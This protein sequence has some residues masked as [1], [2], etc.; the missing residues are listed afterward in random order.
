MKKLKTHKS[1]EKGL[2]EA[3]STLEVG[4]F[5]EISFES[6][7][8]AA[9]LL[10]KWIKENPKGPKYVTKTLNLFDD[11]FLVKKLIIQRIK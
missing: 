5:L 6:R 11:N 8:Y 9:S 2:F 10:S 7:A 1:F 3:V 4:K